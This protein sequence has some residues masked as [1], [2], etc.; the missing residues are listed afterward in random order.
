M[1]RFAPPE[2]GS[3]WLIEAGSPAIYY[4]GPADWCSNPNHAQQFPSRAE[5]EKVSAEMK[6]ANGSPRVAEHSWE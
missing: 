6:F 2:N 3:W 4:C 5:A 1:S